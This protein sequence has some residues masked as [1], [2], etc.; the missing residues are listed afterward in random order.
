MAIISSGQMNRMYC[1]VLVKFL[2]EGSL[3]PEEFFS[4]INARWSWLE[5]RDDVDLGEVCL[6][7]TNVRSP[8]SA[9]CIADYDSI[10]QLAMD[11]AT[12]PG[13]GI[14]NVEVMPISGE[15]GHE[16]L[17]GGTLVP[18]SQTRRRG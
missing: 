9:I 5:I 17:L 7:R 14:S 18:G 11:L 6:D 4:R 1:L 2:P 3:S 10:E 13:A 8:R 16:H 15:R 12:M